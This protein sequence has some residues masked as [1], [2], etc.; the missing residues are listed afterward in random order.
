VEA[1]GKQ[2]SSLLPRVLELAN[3]SAV[4][5]GIEP[6]YDLPTLTQVLAVPGAR[7]VYAARESRVLAAFI[8]IEHARSLYLWAGGI[9][10]AALAE[11]SPY[12]FLMYELIAMAP[13]RG[14]DR[15]EFGRG[16]YR[17][18]RRYGFAGTD[19]WTLFYGADPAE[20]ERLSARLA[21]MHARLADFMDR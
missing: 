18:K 1:T 12:L 21:D 3:G 13:E 11:Y 20:T 19:L 14:W 5:H 4:K 7:I 2:G 8:G 10:Y 6:L 9:D 17:F 15:I 16:N